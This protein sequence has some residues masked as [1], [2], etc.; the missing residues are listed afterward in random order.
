MVIPFGWPTDWAF[1][2]RL[3]NPVAIER[4]IDEHR[5]TF[6]VEAVRDGY[7]HAC[8]VDDIMRIL[9]Q[10]P[11]DDV[12][13]IDLVVLRQPTV[14]QQILRSVWGCILYWS[15]TGHYRGTAIHLEAQRLG[16]PLVWG[17]SL[18]PDCSLEMERLRGDGHEVKLEKRRW[19]ITS[20]LQ[21]IRTTQLYR[22]LIHELGHEV[23]Y[24][25][26]VISPACEVSDTAAEDAART[27]RYSNKP[28][29]EKEAF[30]HRYAEE[31]FHILKSV[32]QAPFERIVDL[33]GMLADGLDLAWF[34]VEV[35]E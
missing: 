21:T 8:T 29:A 30:A 15:D 6:L 22:T 11:I 13:G 32:G 2:E 27:Q 9:K 10:L 28:S 5:I 16:Q 24:M 25:Q 12:D 35:E 1:N 31:Q 18:T 14:K 23:D 4:F 3:V 19:L 20:T 17:K 7:V 26:S 33:A 34:G